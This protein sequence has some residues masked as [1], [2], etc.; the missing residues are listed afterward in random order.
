MQTPHN[1]AIRPVG[2]GVARELRSSLRFLNLIPASL[3]AVRSRVLFGAGAWLLGAVAA[4]AGSLLAVEQLGQ[5]ML[6]QQTTE[7]SVTAVN[8]KLAA[9]SAEATT[10]PQ[11]STGSS[12]PTP[13][14][15]RTARSTR[16]VGRGTP[17]PTIG[18]GK[19]VASQDGTAFAECKPGGAYLV[20]WT[21]QNGFEADH[22]VQGPAAVASVTFRGSTSGVVLK[23]SC[24]GGRPVAHVS[25]LNWGGDDGGGHD[26]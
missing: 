15:S 12:A 24:S 9:E 16:P 23:V 26:D 19:V 7:L 1:G 20:Y 14:A 8:A 17:G 10:R 25:Q 13:S 18:T 5:G 4:T 6:A 21:P 11:A 2:D 22:V 3:D